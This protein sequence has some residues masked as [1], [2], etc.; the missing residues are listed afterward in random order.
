[1]VLIVLV[2]VV[3]ACVCGFVGFWLRGLCPFSCW[4]GVGLDRLHPFG[5]MDV[6]RLLGNKVM[7]FVLL[8]GYL[9][10]AAWI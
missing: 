3:S 1:M 5:L 9:L 10:L 6:G 8:C 2:V 7:R 4:W